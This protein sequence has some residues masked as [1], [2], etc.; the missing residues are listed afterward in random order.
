MLVFANIKEKIINIE[1]GLNKESLVLLVP[2]I[3]LIC[4]KIKTENL[5]HQLRTDNSIFRP[6]IVRD[7]KIEKL[8]FIN[9]CHGIAS[10]IQCIALLIF[11]SSFP[12]LLIPAIFSFYENFISCRALRH[13]NHI[14]FSRGDGSLRI[15]S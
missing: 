7:P 3:S 15:V 2:V 13:V 4:R 10:A 8:D 6:E 11:I 9:K 12:Y 1:Y 5:L 14:E